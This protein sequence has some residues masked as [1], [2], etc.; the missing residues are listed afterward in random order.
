MSSKHQKDIAVDAEEIRKHNEENPEDPRERLDEMV[1]CDFCGIW[2]HK[3][4]LKKD[5]LYQK[6]NKRKWTYTYTE[7]EEIW[8]TDIDV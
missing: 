5:K 1:G 4:C 8:K 2:Y 3:F 6:N 7:F